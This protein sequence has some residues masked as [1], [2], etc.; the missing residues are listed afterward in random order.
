MQGRGSRAILTLVVSVAVTLFVLISLGIDDNTEN[1]HKRNVN[2]NAAKEQQYYRNAAV[3]R[4]EDEPITC[5]NTCTVVNKENMNGISSGSHVSSSTAL[6][7]SINVQLVHGQQ[8]GVDDEENEAEGLFARLLRR[9]INGISRFFF[10]PSE[11]ERKT[12]YIVS[13][14]VIL[15]ELTKHSNKFQSMSQ[16]I[17]DESSNDSQLATTRPDI[18]ETMYT[19]SAENMESTSNAL[20]RVVAIIQQQQKSDATNHNAIDV[21]TLACTVMSLLSVLQAFTIPNIELMIDI[22]Y[23]EPSNNDAL[24][25]AYDHHMST[26]KSKAVVA[27]MANNDAKEQCKTSSSSSSSSRLFSRQEIFYPDESVGIIQ[28]I[29]NIVFLIILFPISI[30]I[31]LLS[32]IFIFLGLIIFSILSLLPGDLPSVFDD[33]GGWSGLIL[34]IIIAAVV[35]APILTIQ[36]LL[37]NI[38]GLFEDLIDPFIPDPPPTPAP[39][40]AFVQ[41]SPN[42]A[43]VQQPVIPNQP[44]NP[45]DQYKLSKLSS[46]VS[47][48]LISPINLIVDMVMQQKMAATDWNQKEEDDVDCQLNQLICNTNALFE[49][50]PV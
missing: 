29:Y 50:L 19:L 22:L 2:N 20:N 37:R 10:R 21:T 5:I 30:I 14:T 27:D 48:V 43:I 49:V 34:I 44:S 1:T 42:S 25:E 32:I 31:S 26:S 39:S 38:G 41:A 23:K 6:S 18:I 17:K 7:Q 24:N 4:Q 16:L 3:R 36:A 28:H 46:H 9:L 8:E 45:R 13:T 35:G 12:R 15:S 11:D 47:K 33:D 40:F